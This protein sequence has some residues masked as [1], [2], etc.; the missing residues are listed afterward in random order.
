MVCLSINACVPP[1]ESAPTP[2]R[3]AS[4]EPTSLPTIAVT[5]SPVPP[6]PTT[7]GTAIPIPTPE[8]TPTEA[9]D[10]VTITILYDNNPG[11]GDERLETAWG[12]S[13]LVKLPPRRGGRGGVGCTWCWAASTWAAR[14]GGGS[15]TSVLTSAG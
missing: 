6:T 12:F 11:G 3:R 9:A 1:R 2:E 14:A 10:S 5:P 13:C 7:T 15:S 4:A 8:P